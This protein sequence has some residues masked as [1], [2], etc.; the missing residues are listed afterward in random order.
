MR[1]AIGSIMHEANT[2]SPV[3]TLLSDFERG[4]IHTGGDIVTSLADVNCEMAGFMDILTEEGVQFVPTIFAKALP[5]GRVTRDAFQ[6]LRDMLLDRLRE[7]GPLDGVL[8]APHGAMAVEGIDDG[9]GEWLEA[10]R[11]EVGGEIPIVVS[12]DM[13]ANITQRRMSLVNA[14]AGYHT[15]PHV[16]M[17]EVG[18]KAA[19]MMLGILRGQ[20]HLA[21]AWRKLPMITSPEHHD[22]TEGPMAELFGRIAQSEGKPGI[23]SA[24]LFAVQPFMDLEELGW[25]T[26]VVADGDGELARS[27]AEDIGDL[28]WQWRR[29]FLFQP[30]PLS[31]AIQRAKEI[32]GGPVI[33]VDCADSPNA[34][35][36]GDSTSVLRALVESDF[37]ETA[38]LTLADADVVDRA[39]QAGVGREIST[40]IGGK[41][42]G[43]PS[44]AITARVKSLSDGQFIQEGPAGKGAR[45]DMQGVAVLQLGNIHLVVGRAP[46]GGHDPQVYR[47]VGLEPRDAKLVVVKSPADFRASYGPFAR[48]IIFPDTPGPASSNLKRL[49]FTR[50]PRPLFPLDDI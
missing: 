28:A 35:A 50:A 45:V 49:D 1:V 23:L 10:V 2:F 7:A 34:G 43:Y 13:H 29:R 48:E 4:G 25:A 6:T 27:E 5:G 38:L 21:M 15:E 20:I 24:N 33:L 37:R 9:D 30:T 18:R 46:D 26:V 42:G 22:T 19:R 47:S 31:E 3:P 12:M 41:R 14:V 32:D 16:D 36:T 8:L 11:S 40:D 17:R 44:L 39:V